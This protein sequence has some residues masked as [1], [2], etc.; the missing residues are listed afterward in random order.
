MK[1]QHL[2]S[3]PAIVAFATLVG[4][5]GCASGV[6][7]DDSTVAATGGSSASSAS[8]TYTQCSPSFPIACR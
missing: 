1:T 6:R 5:A 7:G 3:L 8:P 2:K 4:L